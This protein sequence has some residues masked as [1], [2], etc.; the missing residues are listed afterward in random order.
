MEKQKNESKTPFTNPAETLPL[1]EPL[2][3]TCQW[4]QSMCAGCSLSQPGHCLQCWWE[5]LR[6]ARDGSIDG[7]P[8]QWLKLKK[9]EP[10]GNIHH[11][12]CFTHWTAWEVSQVMEVASLSFLVTCRANSHLIIQSRILQTS[13]FPAGNPAGT[14]IWSHLWT[15]PGERI[16]EGQW[17]HVCQACYIVIKKSKTISCIK[18][19]LIKILLIAPQNKKH[20][21][22]FHCVGMPNATRPCSAWYKSHGVKPAAIRSWSGQVS[23]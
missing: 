17:A 3:A 12:F 1:P 5:Y 11:D 7:C 13:N 19:M 10:Q 18:V 23:T 16:V 14:T 15:S 9:A 20:T 4:S 8:C 2:L 22:R 21:C 6:G